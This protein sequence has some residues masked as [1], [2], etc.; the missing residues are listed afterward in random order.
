VGESGGGT[1]ALTTGGAA[2]TKI[3]AKIRKR[4]QQKNK[5]KH[6]RRYKRRLAN[7]VNSERFIQGFLGNRRIEPLEKGVTPK[8]GD[9]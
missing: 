2:S 6:W 1:G 9:G 4:E 3:E 7:R 8:K 5:G